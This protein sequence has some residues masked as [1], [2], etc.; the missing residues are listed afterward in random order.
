MGRNDPQ[1]EYK[2]L[3]FERACFGDFQQGEVFLDFVSNHRGL[4][5]V[6]VD[7]KATCRSRKT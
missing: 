6:E 2:A 4:K 1:I 7:N 5:N 3:N